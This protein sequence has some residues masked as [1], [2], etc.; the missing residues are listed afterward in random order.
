M[1]YDEFLHQLE[2]LNEDTD[3]IDIYTSPDFQCDQTGG[4]PTSLCVNW[5]KGKAW[6]QLNDNVKTDVVDAAKYE[7]LC[8][9]YG[10]R[11]CPDVE[12]FN[13]ILSS[14]GD[15]ARLTASLPEDGENYTYTM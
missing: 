2:N 15:D 4:F 14:L 8:A 6:L 7:Q 13:Q 9:D 1:T 12:R 11:D 3:A 5:D 10:I